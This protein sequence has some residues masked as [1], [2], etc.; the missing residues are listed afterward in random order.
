MEL[1]HPSGEAAGIRLCYFVTGP[2]KVLASEKFL[3]MVERTVVSR[4]PKVDD[5]Y[6]FLRDLHFA[7]IDSGLGGVSK[8]IE[9]EIEAIG[10]E[11]VLGVVSIG[12]KV[13][14]G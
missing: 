12:K 7:N 6:H 10:G 1:H 13:I 5:L 2:K 3:P 8:K 4:Y 14:L 9:R 11:K